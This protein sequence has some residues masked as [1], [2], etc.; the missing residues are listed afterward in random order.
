MEQQ[1]QVQL[2]HAQVCAHFRFKSISVYTQPD[3]SGRFAGQSL[4]IVKRAPNKVQ[5][6]R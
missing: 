2:K 5:T 4:S 1:H 3:G 6:Q